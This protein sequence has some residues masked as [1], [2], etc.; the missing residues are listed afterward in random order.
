MLTKKMLYCLDL[1]I[2]NNYRLTQKKYEKN[3]KFENLIKILKIYQSPTL[4][5]LKKIIVYQK[6]HVK[7]FN[8][9]STN[10]LLMELPKHH[11][12]L[13]ITIKNNFSLLFSKLL[14]IGIYCMICS[15]DLLIQNFILFYHN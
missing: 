4:K 15:C 6:N 8:V 10:V 13:Y 1:I 12:N 11:C 3:I 7:C 5:Y 2:Q 14:T 9:F